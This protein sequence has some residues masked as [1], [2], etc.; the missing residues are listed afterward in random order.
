MLGLELGFVRV[1]VN[2][3]KVRVRAGLFLDEKFKTEKNKPLIGTTIRRVI[4]KP[5]TEP[6][7]FNFHFWD[8][9][10]CICVVLVQNKRESWGCLSTAQLSYQYFF[11]PSSRPTIRSKFESP[12][13][14]STPPPLPTIRRF[15]PSLLSNCL[16]QVKRMPVP[17]PVPVP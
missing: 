15:S 8:F 9:L 7:I 11:N 17:V 4:M 16:L 2:V 13:R 12:I 10:I 3:K 5:T 1:R 6:T 14:T